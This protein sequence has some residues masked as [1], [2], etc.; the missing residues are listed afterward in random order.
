MAEARSRLIKL[1]GG[2]GIA[3]RGAFHP[4]VEDGVPPLPDGAAVA[5]LALLG[6]VGRGSW[7][8]FAG[9]PEACDGHPDPLDRWSRRV[10]D[11][12]AEKVGAVA[13]YPFRG[14]P[15]LPFQ[16]WAQKAEPVHSSP[17][18]ILIHPDWGLWHG[19][20]GALGF[21]ERLEL[22][23]PDRRASPCASCAEKPCLVACPVGAFQPARYDVAACFGHIAAP[24]GGDCLARGCKARG[25]CP[26]GAA[27]RYGPG[28]AAFHMRAFR[29]ALERTQNQ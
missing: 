8:A 6:V 28:Q 20:R 1:A 11:G 22:P 27:H 29:A 26:I 24:A 5:T 9:S 7:P 17:L 13:L 12:L 23:P 15:W 21:R 18:G 16:R 19:Y 25:A 14:P 10:I 4:E 2:A 3:F